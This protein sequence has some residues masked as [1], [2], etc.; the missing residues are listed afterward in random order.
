MQYECF[1]VDAPYRV[2]SPRW[3]GFAGPSVKAGTAFPHL[4]GVEADRVY[5]IR[6]TPRPLQVLSHA[7]YS[8]RGV[9]TSTESTYYT[10]RSGSGAFNAGTLRWTCALRGYCHPDRMSPSTQSGSPGKSRGTYFG[11]S[12]RGPLHAEIPQLTTSAG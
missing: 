11:S 3:W 9:R 8:C 6:S 10:T 7:T 5:P 12:P 2:V 1:P 4:V